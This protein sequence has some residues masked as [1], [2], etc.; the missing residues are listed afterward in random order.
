MVPRPQGMLAPLMAPH[1]I[2][3][4]VN[5]PLHPGPCGEVLLIRLVGLTGADLKAVND[6]DHEVRPHELSAW[7]FMPKVIIGFALSA[8]TRENEL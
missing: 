5:L 7:M 8:E 6:S 1:L 4:S 3:D 2:P